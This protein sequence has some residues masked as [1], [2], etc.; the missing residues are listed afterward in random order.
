MAKK[1]T[2]CLYCNRPLNW[3]ELRCRWGEHTCKDCGTTPVDECDAEMDAYEALV[4]EFDRQMNGTEEE[5]DD[6]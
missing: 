2:T 6:G 1:R 4:D 3:H 5:D